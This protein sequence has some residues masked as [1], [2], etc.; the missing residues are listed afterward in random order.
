MA[1]F[2]L[3]IEFVEVRLNAEFALLLAIRDSQGYPGPVGLC[4]KL[5]GARHQKPYN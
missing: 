1:Q 2:W 4:Q 5:F 3:I